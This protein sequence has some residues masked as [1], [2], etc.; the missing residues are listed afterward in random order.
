MRLRR[1]IIQEQIGQEE[2]QTMLK[3]YYEVF[4]IIEICVLD[5]VVSIKPSRTTTNAHRCHKFAAW[6]IQDFTED[7]CF[8]FTAM[9]SDQTHLRLNG[10]VN[11]Q[12]K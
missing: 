2:M 6:T 11:R 5:V 12:N 1:W 4:E 9:F 7:F 8:H 10:F 3:L